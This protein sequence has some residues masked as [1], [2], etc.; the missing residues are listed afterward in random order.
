MDKVASY[1]T[2]VF[3]ALRSS[4]I[5]SGKDFEDL[6]AEL[7]LIARYVQHQWLTDVPRNLIHT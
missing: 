2:V 7:Q 3:E 5:R 4:K 6:E 1:A